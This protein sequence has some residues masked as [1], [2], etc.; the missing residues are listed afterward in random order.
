M[1]LLRR[2]SIANNPQAVEMME[3]TQAT[4]QSRKTVDAILD[5][6]VTYKF[7][8]E[9]GTY[10]LGAIVL[11]LGGLTLLANREDSRRQEVTILGLQKGVADAEKALEEERIKRAKLME[12]VLW[13][14]G[15]LSLSDWWQ[16][17]HDQNVKQALLESPD[18]P[19]MPK[20]P[21]V[22]VSIVCA[23]ERE[24]MWV[25]YALARTLNP[26]AFRVRELSIG[27]Y[28]PQGIVIDGPIGAT[29]K[30]DFRQEAADAILHG[31]QS[32]FVSARIMPARLPPNTVRIIVGRSDR[33]AGPTAWKLNKEMRGWEALEFP[34]PIELRTADGEPPVTFDFD[35]ASKAHAATK[36]NNLPANV[37]PPPE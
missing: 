23:N 16:K 28:L 1:F 24:P 19:Q 29:D 13:R 18:D 21:M 26:S 10:V 2:R 27:E 5:W 20:K 12:S 22:D 7:W 32:N 25:A 30:E 9:V 4:K 8:F 11:V 37:I 36:A 31:L 33:L 6:L 34:P 15:E 17:K 35:S 14:N 3:T